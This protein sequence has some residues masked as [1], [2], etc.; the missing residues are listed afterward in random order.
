MKLQ[1]LNKESY[2]K[3]KE[4]INNISI[5]AFGEGYLECL[6][7]YIENDLG[8]C[9]ACFIDEKIVGFITYHKKETHE[10]FEKN[11]VDAIG[12]IKTI[13]VLEAHKGKSV[14]SKLFKYAEEEL[15]LFGVNKIIVP[16]WKFDDQ[17]N[18]SR[19]LK[20]YEYKKYLENKLYWKNE[21]E[22]NEF[23]CPKKT[24]KFCK[25]SAIFYLKSFK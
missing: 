13:V 21:C 20:K 4:S 9:L 3:N 12:E 23:D 2:S 25:C 11:N 1:I 6:L 17:I 24:T 18:I 14:G 5:E 10:L 8:N 22:N 15:L 16:A 7:K 19:L